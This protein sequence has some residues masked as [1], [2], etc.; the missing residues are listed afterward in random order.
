MK[1]IEVNPAKYFF[2]R[3]EIKKNTIAKDVS[4]FIWDNMFSI[5]PSLLVIGL[6]SQTNGNGMYVGNPLNLKHYSTTEVG[7][8]L[9]GKSAPSR[10]LKLDFGDD[11]KYDTA[12]H[13]L[14]EAYENINKDAGLNLGRDDCGHEYALYVFPFNPNCLNAQSR[15]FLWK[16][17]LNKII[18]DAI[19]VSVSVFKH[20]YSV[21]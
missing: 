3:T 16:S 2:N 17:N 18:Q 10:P 5:K 11:R 19:I 14:F 8:Y 13:N 20:G 4:G 21:T 6:I 12:Y 9:N 1:T 7:L 15:T